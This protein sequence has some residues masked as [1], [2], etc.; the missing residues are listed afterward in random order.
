MQ[1]SLGEV[2]QTRLD[3][4]DELPREL[5]HVD[6]FGGDRDLLFVIGVVRQDLLEIGDAFEVLE[7]LIFVRSKVGEFRR[8]V[9][10]YTRLIH[11]VFN[12]RR[13]FKALR[14]GPMYCADFV[15]AICERV[16]LRCGA[17]AVVGVVA[18]PGGGSWDHPR[19]GRTRADWLVAPSPPSGASRLA[20]VLLTEVYS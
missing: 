6:I 8:Y 3:G 13:G 15:A 10:L 2:L 9:R 14:T 19:N 17:F 18:G 12:L 4:R 16:S 5:R 7:V 1:R 20:G 11:F